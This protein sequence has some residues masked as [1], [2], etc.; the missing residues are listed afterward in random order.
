MNNFQD[1]YYFVI[2]VEKESIKAASRFLNIPISTLSRRIQT[3]E[4]ELGY[5]LIHRTAKRF[6]LTEAGQRLYQSV[7]PVVHELGMRMDDVNSELSSLSGDIKITAPPGIGHHYLKPLVFEFMRQNPRLT[8][9]LFL[10]NENVDLVRNSIDIAFRIGDVTLNDWVSRPLFSSGLVLVAKPGLVRAE[11]ILRHPSQLTNYPLICTRRMPV[12]RFHKGDEQAVVVPKPA[13]RTDEV[14]FAVDTVRQ[15]F[16][17][18][19]LP[20][21]LVT[22]LL[23]S[24]ELQPLLPEWDAGGRQVNMIYPHRNNLP[25]KTRAF[26]DFIIGRLRQEK[27]AA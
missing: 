13:F 18:A 9:E 25:A 6:G 23:A 17:I 14:Q 7:G 2:V 26:I 1:L 3:F 4:E 10:T 20:E 27:L 11:Q 8:V 5:K 16:G 24:G 15:G 12:W 19:C 21:Y 22:D